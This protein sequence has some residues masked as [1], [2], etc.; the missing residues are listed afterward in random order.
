MA[1]ALGI[2]T[3]TTFSTTDILQLRTPPPALAVVLSLLPTPE[4]LLWGPSNP[5]SLHSL[6]DAPRLFECPTLFILLGFPFLILSP[7]ELLLLTSPESFRI[8]DG[9]RLGIEWRE[10]IFLS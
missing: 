10:G 3:A 1:S 5:Y 2:A 4:H 7:P 6:P 8:R 9:E